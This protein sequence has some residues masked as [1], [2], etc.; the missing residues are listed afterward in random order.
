MIKVTFEDHGQDFLEWYIQNGKVVACRPFQGWLW[1]G[2]KV[3]NKTIQPG[4]ILQIE[5]QSGARLKLLY[6]VEKVVYVVN[7]ASSLGNNAN[8]K[9]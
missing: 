5:N 1:E 4:D 6:P 2:T 8:L 7:T 9:R 3:H